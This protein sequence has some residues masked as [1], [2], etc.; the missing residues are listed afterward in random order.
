MLNRML[1]MASFAFVVFACNGSDKFFSGESDTGVQTLSDASGDQIIDYDQDGYASDVDCNDMDATVHPGATELANCVDDNCDGTIDEGTDNEDLH[2]CN[3]GPTTD[4]GTTTLPQGDC[5]TLSSLSSS[6]AED[7]AK[8]MEICSNLVSANLNVADTEARAIVSIL[9]QAKTDL[10]KPK[11]GEAMVLLST[12]K[13]VYNPYNNDEC[14]Q[15]GTDFVDIGTDPDPDIDDTY[16]YDVSSLSLTLEVPVG[17]NSF[18][19]D[20]NFL[21]T[22]YP[23][24]LGSEF[25][26]TFWV[27]LESKGFSGNISFD[28]NGT[29]IRLNAAFFDICDPWSQNPLTLQYCSSSASQL[30]GTGYYKE[31]YNDGGFFG[32]GLIDTSGEANGG[33]TGWLTTTAPVEPGETIKLTFYIFDKGDGILDSSVLIDN[34]KWLSDS[35]NGPETKPRIE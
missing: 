10:G 27:K 17:A 12:G 13:A 28:K 3:G 11:K 5:D 29:P 20:F 19:F 18:S 6:K 23:E 30:E 22:E 1:I 16:A 8:A 25:N 2:L 32:G 31:C 24:Y 14:P 34:F 15:M 21:T 7:Y 26:D 4:A 35:S 9:G 33:A